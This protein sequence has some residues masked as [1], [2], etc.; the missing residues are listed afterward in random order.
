MIFLRSTLFKNAFLGRDVHFYAKRF[1]RL[2]NYALFCSKKSIKSYSNM[3]GFLQSIGII[4][5][6]I[7]SIILILSYFM[8]WNN[9]NG[10]QFG[11]MAL[12]IV[13]V[14]VYIILNKKHQ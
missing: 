12:I 14:I 13:G 1:E 4:L 6:I 11:G 8:G 2:K 10:V 5:M 9:L 7:G 3:K